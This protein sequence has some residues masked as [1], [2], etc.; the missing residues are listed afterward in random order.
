MGR[1]QIY[2]L[3]KEEG[4][5]HGTVARAMKLRKERDRRNAFFFDHEKG[6]VKIPLGAGMREYVQ[7]ECHREYPRR[8]RWVQIYVTD[9]TLDKR[10]A[11]VTLD[12]T[13]YTRH[14]VRSNITYQPRI[15]SFG[16]ITRRLL[17]WYIGT[18]HAIW[19][20]RRG[21]HFGVNSVRDGHNRIQTQLYACRDI[22][23]H[24]PSYRF[25][26]NSDAILHGEKVF[27]SDA[28][29]RVDAMNGYHRKE[30]ERKRITSTVITV[31]LVV[32]HN[33]VRTILRVQRNCPVP[34]DFADR[35]GW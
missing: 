25:Y 19:R 26:F 24:D 32:P 27:W 33:G 21:W 18:Q 3:M 4:K 22:Y 14:G 11:V 35:R 34:S 15:R 31:D 10:V 13:R 28:K 17:C 1:K 16:V 30:K 8:T 20:A 23:S 29:D 12:G 9:C 2:S 5:L 6:R 7:L